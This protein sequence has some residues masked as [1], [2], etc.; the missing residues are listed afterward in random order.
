MI[1]KSDEDPQN[2]LECKFFYLSQVIA[3]RDAVRKK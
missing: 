2:L 1:L 3:V